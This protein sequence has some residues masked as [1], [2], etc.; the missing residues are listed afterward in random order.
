MF[1]FY[2]FLLPS[3]VG[4]TVYIIINKCF[5]EKMKTKVERD[6]GG[7]DS[8]R[9]A[10][11]KALFDKIMKDR[12]LKVA[13]LTVF[14][15]AG[16]QHFQEEIESLLSHD[17]FKR[18]CRRNVNGDLKLVCDIIDRN[19]FDVYSKPIR[20]LLIANGLNHSDKVTLLKI[21]LDYIINGE[22]YGKRRFLI[23]LLIS[24]L[25]TVTISGVSGLALFLEA[26]Y[27]LFKEGRISR[28]LYEAI[29]K[30]LAKK[31]GADI[32]PL[33]DFL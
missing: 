26:L 12:A 18:I 20:E 11:F 27:K 24:A 23:M 5:P 13:L 29:L 22:C 4:V 25:V 15:A 1:R 2:R 3:I 33:E 9:S 21:K 16:A 17:I 30:S 6:L 14:F 28:A 19:E 10:I 31:Y 7:G 8:G 32:P